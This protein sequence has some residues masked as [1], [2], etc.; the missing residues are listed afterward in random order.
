MTAPLI[1]ENGSITLPG[2]T[3][4]AAVPD[5]KTAKPSLEDTLAALDEA[6]RAF[7]LGEVTSARS[8]AKN[9]RE[10]LKAAEPKV[11][12]YDRLVA[13][14]K[15]AE[16]QAQEATRAAEQRAHAANQRVARAEVKAALA[17]VVDNPDAIV[18]DLNLAKFVNDDGEIDTSAIQALRDKYA[19]FGSPRAPRPDASQAS[20]ANGT[21]SS[22]PAEEF[23]SFIRAQIGR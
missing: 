14:S 6:D 10:R 8:E 7:V 20:G 23:A 11:S 12:E 19:G 4:A 18:D 22:G 17:G 5:S 1:D 3:P 2:Q 13:A 21:Q 9:L 16:E 15:T